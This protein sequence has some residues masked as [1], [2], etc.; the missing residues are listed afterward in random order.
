MISVIRVLGRNFEAY[1]RDPAFSTLIADGY[2]PI[3]HM[4]VEESEGRPPEILMLM[5]KDPKSSPWT[6]RLLAAICVVQVVLVVLNTIGL[7]IR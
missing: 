4:Q 7:L 1:L 6:L 5:V 3:M 2:R